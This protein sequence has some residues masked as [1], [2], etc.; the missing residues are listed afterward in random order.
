MPMSVHSSPMRVERASPADLGAVR[1]AYA[2]ARGIQQDRGAILW[3][4][5]SDATILAEI[6]D[7]RLY[8]V[9][10]GSALVGVFSV[11]YT[12]D[13]IWG[14]RERGAHLYLHR[15]ARAGTGEARGL[16]A[17]V[18]DWARAHCRALGR[19]GLRIDTW[20]SNGE[21]IAF[22]E[23]HGFQRVGECR[24]ATD[25]R[26]PAHYHNREFALLEAPGELPLVETRLERQ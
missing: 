13:A 10:D 2:H 11:A 7:G 3:P 22:Y 25:P 9:T 19:E 6:A 20:A 4:E 1:A 26:L 14:E 15:I 12:D 16:V 18:L 17:A 21:L 24:I 5:F 8:R 23:R